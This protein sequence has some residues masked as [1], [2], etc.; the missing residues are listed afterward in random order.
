MK[1]M[2]NIA[3]KYR[4]AFS[5]TLLVVFIIVLVISDHGVVK[6]QGVSIAMDLIGFIMVLIGGIGRLW[7]SLYIEGNKNRKLISDGPYSMMRN[8]LYI[9]SMLLLIGYILLIKSIIIGVLFLS[10]FMLL[11]MSTIYNEEKIL[12]SR[13]DSAYMEYFRKTPRFIPKLSLYKA[14]N[15]QTSIDINVKKIESVMIEVAGFI[16]F[17]GLIKLLDILHKAEYIKTYLTLY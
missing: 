14:S 7:S 8:P 12:L 10:I 17:F 6:S 11:Y 2:K 16:L 1:K 3:A 5:K 9:F 15:S 13:H 4:L